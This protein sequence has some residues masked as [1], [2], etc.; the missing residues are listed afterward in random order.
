MLDNFAFTLYEI[1]GYLIP[2]GIVLLGLTLIFWALFLPAVP[3]PVATLQPGLVGWV[4]FIVASYLLGHAV[5]G[6]A[7]IF[8]KGAESAALGPQGTVPEPIRK[9]AAE[10]SG[11]L[12]NVPPE[13]LDSGWVFR[14]LDEHCVQAGELGDR[15]MFVYREGFYRGTS[16]ALFFLATT[17][18]V[19]TYVPGTV[20]QFTKGPFYVSHL[21][22][23]F[24]ALV[25]AAVGWFF[26]QRY[27]R[28]AAYRVTHAV[29]AALVLQNTPRNT[30][31]DKN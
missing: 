15:D 21:Q 31:S 25:V 1:F 6:I 24:T 30:G 9:A 12:L 2:G 17:L 27:R 19:R 14:A 8:L 18:I 4:G 16:L 22:G 29:T 28:F 10:F 20:L 11:K 5:Q 3:I 13:K 26:V 7:N 23:L